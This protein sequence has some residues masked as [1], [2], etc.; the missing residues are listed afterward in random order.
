MLIKTA[1]E[2]DSQI[3]TLRALVNRSDVQP[4][5]RKRI[6]QEIRNIQAGV[7]GEKEAGYEIGFHCGNSQNWMVLHDLRLELEGRVAQ[8]DHLVI[9]RLLEMYVCESK[10]FSEG[11]AVNEQG[12]FSAFWEHKPYG[13]ASPIEQNKK[14]MLVLERLFATGLVKLPTRMGF[15]IKPTIKSLVLV[16]KNARISRPK[17]TVDG[18]ECIIKNDQFGTHIGKEMDQLSPL[19]LTKVVGCDTLKD[20][21]EKIALRHKPIEIDWEGKFGLSKQVPEPIEPK[22]SISEVANT[23]PSENKGYFCSSCKKSVTD[24]VAKFCWSNTTKFGGKVFCMP[25]QKKCN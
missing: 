22:Q 10:H 8:I 15:A 4:D 20:L 23:Q 1:D 17:S 5:V 2:K 24:T 7:R 13:V 14:H 21:A 16:S 9:N 25:C 6:E 19:M 12:E 3:V 11:I 18:M